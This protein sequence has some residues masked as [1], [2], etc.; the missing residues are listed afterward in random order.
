MDKVICWISGT[1]YFIN[2]YTLCSDLSFRWCDSPFEQPGPGHF[3]MANWGQSE[4]KSIFYKHF[5]IYWIAL[6]ALKP[7]LIF[8]IASKIYWVSFLLQLQLSSFY[9]L[10]FQWQS[11]HKN[12]KY[13]LP[14]VQSAK[15]WN[16]FAKVWMNINILL[17]HWRKATLPW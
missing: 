1:V 14:N 12:F 10:I 11:L 17:D 8:A 5:G 7:Q 2:T 15:T 3:A 6:V 9:H 13:C 16:G 4:I